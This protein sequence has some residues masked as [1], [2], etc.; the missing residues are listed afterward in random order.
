MA[1]VRISQWVF[2]WNLVNSTL[3]TVL[4]GLYP[5]TIGVAN[6]KICKTSKSKTP[7]NRPGNQEVI[8]LL[9]NRSC[10][11]DNDHCGG[12]GAWVDTHK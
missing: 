5:L 6:G 2:L 12:E 3:G 1:G 7:D 10:C 9:E 4:D 8:F 11:L